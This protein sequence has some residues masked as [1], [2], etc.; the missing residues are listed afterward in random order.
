M[1]AL[2]YFFTFLLI[3][4][5]AEYCS[6]EPIV[7]TVNI[8]ADSAKAEQSVMYEKELLQ[9]QK[10]TSKI[11][12]ETFNQKSKELSV[13]KQNF[14]IIDK[15]NWKNKVAIEIFNDDEKKWSEYPIQ[16]HLLD[17]KQESS[18]LKIEKNGYYFSDL[19]ID[20]DDTGKLSSG[21]QKIRARLLVR[22]VDK[23]RTDTVY[24]EP[25]YINLLTEK[26][27]LKDQL[28]LKNLSIYYSRRG[29][30]EKAL[31]YANLFNEVCTND[32]EGTILLGQM[33]EAMGDYDNAIKYFITAKGE[34]D[35]LP[36]QSNEYLESKIQEILEIS[37]GS[38]EKLLKSGR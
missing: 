22:N 33:Y 5:Q 36:H 32:Y 35:S 12:E 20:P 21:Q 10:R 7:F 4:G 13:K 26:R 31:E 16:T 6:N 17:N 29:L 34:T 11:N 9:Y 19:G 27:P 1:S 23:K 30:N 24:S 15:K 18:T 37:P 25:V 3:P 14:S 8:N 28:F 38:I 2:I